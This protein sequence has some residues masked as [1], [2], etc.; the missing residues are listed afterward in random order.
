MMHRGQKELFSTQVLQ[1]IDA[2]LVWVSFAVAAMLRGPI[3]NI[4]G[5]GGGDDLGLEKMMWVV[6]IAVPLTPLIL[7]KF[8]FYERV[9]VKKRVQV[10]N[11]LLISIFLVGL[12]I[13]LVAVIFQFS[14]TR[15]AL[16]LFVL[17]KILAMWCLGLPAKYK[18][19][20]KP[21]TNS[22]SH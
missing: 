6:Y 13:T 15:K 20:I 4:S 8:E 3:R 16:Y 21:P 19:K 18:F 17:Q 2:L 10:V 22:G 11:Q 1:L 5:L 12:I 14:G 7:E 9:T